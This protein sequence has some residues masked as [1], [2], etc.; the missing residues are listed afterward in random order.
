MTLLCFIFVLLCLLSF[1][2]PLSL[3]LYMLSWL[4]LNSEA[5]NS[6]CLLCGIKGTH[7]QP[8]PD[9]PSFEAGSLAAPESGARQPPSKHQDF[10]VSA[11]LSTGPQLACSVTARFSLFIFYCTQIS[12]VGRGIT[13]MLL[14]IGSSQRTICRNQFSLSIMGSQTPNSGQQARQQ[15]PYR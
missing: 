2:F 11:S 3:V 7:N 9:L 14:C 8:R 12:Y 6:L 10:T 4:F 1:V 13:C 15:A 5:C